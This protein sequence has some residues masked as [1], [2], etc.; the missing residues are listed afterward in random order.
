MIKDIF[1]SRP[2][3]RRDFKE[4]SFIPVFFFSSHADFEFFFFYPPFFTPSFVKS[5]SLFK[6]IPLKVFRYHVYCTASSS[7]SS[8]FKIEIKNIS[9]KLDCILK[10]SAFVYTFASNHSK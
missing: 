10:S 8:F 5:Y 7:S 6:C 3:R 4:I 9:I 2:L 1:L